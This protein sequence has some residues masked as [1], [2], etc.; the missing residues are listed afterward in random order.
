MNE[1]LEAIKAAREVYLDAGMVQYEAYFT[2][3]I[4]ALEAAIAALDMR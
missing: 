1:A 2:D 3:R 4:Q